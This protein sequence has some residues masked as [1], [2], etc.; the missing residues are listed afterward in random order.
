MRRALLD[1]VKTRSRDDATCAGSIARQRS[2][3]PARIP[4]GRLCGNVRLPQG[5]PYRR[6]RTKLS[7]IMGAPPGRRCGPGGRDTLAETGE[8]RLQA[9]DRWCRTGS[10]WLELAR[11]GWTRRGYNSRGFRFSQSKQMVMPKPGLNRA[12][13]ETLHRAL[14]LPGMPV[15]TNCPIGQMFRS[16]ERRRAPSDPPSRLARGRMAVRRTEMSADKFSVYRPTAA[17]MRLAPWPSRPKS[18]PAMIM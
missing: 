16:S 8:R 7:A 18:P 3:P 14:G 11:I 4:A 15:R 10:N 17:R 2:F 6:W 1:M 13:S 12:G 9:G 5:G